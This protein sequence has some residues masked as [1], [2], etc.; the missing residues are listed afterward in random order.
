[1]IVDY[2]NNTATIRSRVNGNIQWDPNTDKNKT[3]Y[4]FTDAISGETYSYLVDKVAMNVTDNETVK[5]DRI[6][7]AVSKID[8]ITFQQSNGGSTI[9][10]YSYNDELQPFV[11]RHEL[12]TLDEYDIEKVAP[13]FINIEED[14]SNSAKALWEEQGISDILSTAQGKEEIKGVQNKFYSLGAEITKLENNIQDLNSQLSTDFDKYKKYY[15]NLLNDITTH[16]NLVYRYWASLVIAKLADKNLTIQKLKTANA[17]TINLN[18]SFANAIQPY[19]TNNQFEFAKL[20]DTFIHCDDELEELITEEEK[21]LEKYYTAGIN[22]CNQANSFLSSIEIYQ[23]MIEDYEEENSTLDTYLNKQ[24]IIFTGNYVICYIGAIEAQSKFEA[25]YNALKDDDPLKS[26][27][28]SQL[29]LLAYNINLLEQTKLLKQ[30]KFPQIKFSQTIYESYHN[31][32]LSKF[33][34]MQIFL[35]NVSNNI[36]VSQIAQASNIYDD[37]KFLSQNIKSYSDTLSPLPLSIRDPSTNEQIAIIDPFVDTTI[38]L[39]ILLSESQKQQFNTY[40]DQSTY[41]YRQIFD[42]I[43]DSSVT[44]TEN[45]IPY[46]IFNIG[47]KKLVINTTSSD[48]PYKTFYNFT[49]ED[50]KDASNNQYKFE[51]LNTVYHELMAVGAQLMQECRNDSSITIVNGKANLDDI[52]DWFTKRASNA[53]DALNG[54]STVQNTIDSFD[55]F[56]QPIAQYLGGT[57]AITIPGINNLLNY[58]FKS[59][60]IKEQDSALHLGVIA[61]KTAISTGSTSWWPSD[62]NNQQYKHI[63]LNRDELHKCTDIIQN[64]DE[65]ALEEF[66]IYYEYANLGVQNKI[67]DNLELLRQAQNLYHLYGQQLNSYIAKYNNYD[68]LFQDNKKTYESYFGTKAYEYYRLV[69]DSEIS[70]EA[71]TEQMKQF[72]NDVRTAWWYFLSLL[73]A[74]YTDERK[75]G[76]YK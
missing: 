46:Y 70:T 36:N 15:D 11:E 14:A 72:R 59:N 35:T 1:M 73:D 60:G 21:E 16:N 42:T 18:S 20:E 38:N 68:L 53:K 2:N 12:L 9:L 66:G 37:L 27:Y 44:K 41:Y 25:L 13:H 24:L 49:K 51:L 19:I 40:K 7:N 63:Y 64:G 29:N 62:I 6:T 50:Y 33:L 71:K 76:M 45:N 28:S 52:E 22:L 65:E 10:E 54:T 8:K 17:S 43:N 57:M 56:I 55:N 67:D 30:I 32:L 26:Q 58:E 3:L 23:R 4:K 61:V 47:S 74:K 39:Q 34:N 5:F 75:R 48:S 31:S 69:N